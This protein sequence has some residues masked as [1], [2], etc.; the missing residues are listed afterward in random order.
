M[1]YQCLL[2]MQHWLVPRACAGCLGRAGPDRDFC[3]GCERSL[4]VIGPACPRC[5]LP[6]AASPEVAC[7]RCQRQ[8]PPFE[9]TLA[10]FRYEDPIR[11][12]IQDLKYSGQLHLAR[13]FGDLMAVRLASLPA[14]PDRIIP[15]PLHPSR[16]RER[17]FNQSV[18]IARPV[19]RRLDVPLDYD[20]LTRI[21]ATT[22][23][24]ALPLDQRRR[25]VRGAFQAFA[26]LAGKRVALIDDVM[27]SGHTAAAAAAALR[28]AGAAV[29]VWIVA[30]AGH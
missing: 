29:E 11:G 2:N 13:L 30:R 28:K 7:G 23:Q 27:T 5:A 6:L 16:L 14:R 22:P 3:P 25:N 18:E 1:V 26:T 24:T 10:L 19:A 4:P 21:R 8:P 12:L 20:A 9:R 15:M 17:G